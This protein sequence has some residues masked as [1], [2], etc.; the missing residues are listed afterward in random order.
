MVTTCSQCALVFDARPQGPRCP[1]CGVPAQIP[2]AFPLPQ[3]LPS[4]AA[5]GPRA[6]LAST[7]PVAL[8]LSIFAFLGACINPV[9]PVAI[10]L[11]V[12]AYSA[13][14][15]TDTALAEVRAKSALR[16]SIVAVVAT[17]VIWLVAAVWYLSGQTLTLSSIRKSTPAA[18]H[19]IRNESLSVHRR[20]RVN[21]RHVV[22]P[23]PV[24][25]AIVHE[26]HPSPPTPM[27]A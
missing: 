11:S 23:S 27:P 24:G 1:R 10:I 6:D 19:T 13:A 9:A 2:G 3:G 26:V 22:S 25:D 17:V 18:L 5:Q 14:Q 16:T 15:G 4:A 12:V 8:V 7:A 21:V 20:S